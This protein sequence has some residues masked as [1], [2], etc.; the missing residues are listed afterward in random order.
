M[1]HLL[2]ATDID[3][4]EKDANICY[5]AVENRIRLAGGFRGGS[6]VMKSRLYFQHSFFKW[7]VNVTYSRDSIVE[8]PRVETVLF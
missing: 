4:C 2:I 6:D 7:T 3:E 5:R 8:T 1:A